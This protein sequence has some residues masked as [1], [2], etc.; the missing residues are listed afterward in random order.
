MED[1]LK[2]SKWD[3]FLNFPGQ[4]REEYIARFDYELNQLK[5]KK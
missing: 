1:E 5:R 2:N 3:P 4:S